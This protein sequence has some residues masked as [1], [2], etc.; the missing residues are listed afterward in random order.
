MAKPA[1]MHIASCA[2]PGTLALRA[3]HLGYSKQSGVWRKC[4]VLLY[5]KPQKPMALQMSGIRVAL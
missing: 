2:L 3:S 5:P 4:C 1:G